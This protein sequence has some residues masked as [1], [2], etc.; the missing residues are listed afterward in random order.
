MFAQNL[1]KQLRLPV[2]LRLAM[3]SVAIANP[4][5]KDNDKLESA[6]AQQLARALYS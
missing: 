2:K 5:T 4:I 6:A 3:T 1:R